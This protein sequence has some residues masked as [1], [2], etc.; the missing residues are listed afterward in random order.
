MH[1]LVYCGRC[2]WATLNCQRPKLVP[3]RSFP[4]NKQED[5]IRLRH[6]LTLRSVQEILAFI[7][8]NVRVIKACW[9]KECR[10]SL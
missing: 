4:E 5:H 7:S 2:L 6:V 8:F 3:L 1:S 10:V 9:N